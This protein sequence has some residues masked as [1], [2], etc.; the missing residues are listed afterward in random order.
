LGVECQVLGVGAV[1]E[2]RW[3][4]ETRGVDEDEEVCCGGVVMF[5]EVGEDGLVERV[6]YSSPI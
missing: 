2:G 4:G 3:G 5:G 6:S 1:G